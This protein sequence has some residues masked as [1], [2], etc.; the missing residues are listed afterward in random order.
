[1]KTFLIIVLSIALGMTAS[2]FYWNRLTREEVEKRVSVEAGRVCAV[3]ADVGKKAMDA[4]ALRY[5]EISLSR[6][7]C[8][9]ANEALN[10]QV[11]RL[12]LECGK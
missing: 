8:T 3:K 2:T 4:C 9:M 5:Q 10:T 7:I 12:K 6:E 11:G 1:M